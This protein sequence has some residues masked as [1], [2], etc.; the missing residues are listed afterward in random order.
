M[1][2]NK[3]E[4][5]VEATEVVNSIEEASKEQVEVSKI[6]VDPNKFSFNIMAL[7]RKTRRQTKMPLV[8]WGV[9]DHKGNLLTAGN[10]SKT[11]EWA[12]NHRMF[13]IN[14]KGQEQI[15]TTVKAKFVYR[16]L[17]VRPIN[18][19]QKGAFKTPIDLNQPAFDLRTVKA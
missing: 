11:S 3:V 15:E 16:P 5:P 17:F 1:E 19:T 10:Y 7:N 4:I 6:S 14:H 18:L 13:P 2:E 8:M 9:Y 12:N